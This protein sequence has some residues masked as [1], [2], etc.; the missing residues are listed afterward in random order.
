MNEPRDAPY[1]QLK[2]THTMA[3]A[4]RPWTDYK[5]PA[6]APIWAAIEGFGRF[7]VLCAALELDVF[8][9]LQELGSSTADQVAAR[10]SV[11]AP[12]LRTLLDAVVALGLIDQFDGAYELN[13]T[14]RRYLVSDGPACMAG[15]V[16]V[17]P[18]PL[19]NWA[20]LADTVREGRP[21]RPID[22]DPE[23]FYVPLVEGTFPTMWRCATRADA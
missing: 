23:A 16:G 21:A 5:P 3:H 18:G 17:A 1:P 9:T 14:A 15:L 22:N 8:D 20:K 10:L 13:D 12:H 7:H 4:G 6:A 11:S 2:K 19:E